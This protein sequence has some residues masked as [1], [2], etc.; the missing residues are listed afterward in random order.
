MTVDEWDAHVVVKY[1][2]LSALERLR[3]KYPELGEIFTDYEQKRE[4]LDLLKEEIRRALR[5]LRELRAGHG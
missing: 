5:D 4:E 3:K 2:S 1:K